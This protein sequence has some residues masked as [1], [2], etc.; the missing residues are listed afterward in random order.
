M[1]RQIIVGYDARPASEDAVALGKLLAGV[2]GATLVVAGVFQFDPVWGGRDPHFKEAEEEYARQVEAAA[3]AAG[4]EAEAVPSSSPAHGLHDLA[5]ERGADLV[6]VGSAS[7]G[8]LGQVLVGNVGLSLLHGSP[9]A[10]AIAP[11]G[12][13]ESAAATLSGVTVG[14][15]GSDEARTA[16]AD[17]VDLARA[18]GAPLKVAT[19]VEPPPLVYG[20]GGGATQG[21]QE[22]KGAAEEVMRGRLDEALASVPGDVSAEGELVTGDPAEELAKIALGDGG[23]LVLGS[24]AYGPLRRVLLGSASTALVRSAPCAVIVHPRSAEGAA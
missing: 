21:W 19:V 7:H 23:V 15:D 6:I 9:C 13:A 5:E 18:A 1:Y 12:F 8:T 10:V 20:K 16:L 3:K 2:T 11:R 4:A 22:L 17:A 14:F 24:R